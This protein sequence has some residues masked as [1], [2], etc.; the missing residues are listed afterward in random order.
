M[1]FADAAC[2][3]SGDKA[4]TWPGLR[5]S[6]F[7]SS[8]IANNFPDLDAVY[9]WI[10]RPQPLGSLLH[11]RGHTHT[12]ILALPLGLLVALAVLRRAER[13]HGLANPQARA[14]VC[15]LGLLGGALHLL[16][17]YGNNY[18]VHPFW[19]LS[20]RWFYGDAIFIVEPLW[21]VVLLPGLARAVHARWLRGVLYGLLALLLGLALLLP[22]VTPAGVL[23]LVALAAIS[24]SVAR[25]SS[26]RVRSATLLGGCTAIALVFLAGS[27]AAASKLR[28]AASRE[29]PA[30][31]LTD[32]VLSP[33]PGNP[34]CWNALVVG[35]Q[36]A[37]YQVLIAQVAPLP[38]WITAASCP[39]DTSARPTATLAPLA[40]GSR[41]ELQ[42]RARYSAPLAELRSLARE[43]CRFRT[44]LRFARVPYLAQ[45]ISGPVA[46]DLRF[47]RAPGLDFADLSLSPPRVCPELVPPWSPPRAELLPD[48]D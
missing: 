30:L 19:P 11:H 47:D 25:L 26:A 31:Q 1:A 35:A 37:Q 32:A 40:A 45:A 15:A 14:W 23:T 24:G 38:G 22:F 21:L 46:G 44:L 8:V 39:Y 2:V 20:S 3:W 13:R 41:P 6:A 5:T 28:S 43:D 16:L 36:A 48:L 34:L 4:R 42:W 7:A 12:L 17:D 29:F 33:M 18:G 9:T 27:A 10:T